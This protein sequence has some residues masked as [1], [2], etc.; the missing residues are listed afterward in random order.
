LID[1]QQRYSPTDYRVGIVNCHLS[2]VIPFQSPSIALHGTATALVRVTK[3][4]RWAKAEG[5]VKVHVLLD[6]SKAFDLINHG[7]FVHKLGSR[8]DFFPPTIV[9]ME[10]FRHFFGIVLWSLRLMKWNLYAAFFVV[11]SPTGMHPFFAVFSKFINDLYSCIRFSK[12]YFYADNLQIYMSGDI[13]HF[14]T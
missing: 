5:K 1:H 11:W 3:Y 4:L 7:Q 8:Y 12:N 14:C 6:F 9:I 2:N 10:W 13:K